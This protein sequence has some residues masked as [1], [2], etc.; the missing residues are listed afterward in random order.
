MNA[1]FYFSIDCF[2]KNLNKHLNELA[3][4]KYVVRP[5]Y[6]KEKNVIIHNQPNKFIVIRPLLLC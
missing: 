2:F 1:F 4:L 3:N 5:Q 6:I